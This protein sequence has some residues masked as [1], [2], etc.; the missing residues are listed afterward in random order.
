LHIFI[1]SWLTQNNIFVLAGSFTLKASSNPGTYQ[2]NTKNITY[3][4][5]LHKDDCILLCFLGRYNQDR[6]WSAYQDALQD[7]SSMYFATT[8]RSIVLNNENITI[9]AYNNASNEILLYY[10]IV[11]MKIS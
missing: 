8:G 10:K 4:S 5:G 6:G 3:P 2:L 9:R 11:L 7:S 1:L